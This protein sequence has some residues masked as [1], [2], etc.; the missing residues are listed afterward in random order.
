MHV[1][2]C[3]PHFIAFF[4]NVF[5]LSILRYLTDEGHV[6]AGLSSGAI[7]M[8]RLPHI[9]DLEPDR[10]REPLRVNP[11]VYSLHKSRTF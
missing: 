4:A 11:Y 6:F 8:W 9:P 3:T 1:Q 5:L 7:V 2:I 10:A